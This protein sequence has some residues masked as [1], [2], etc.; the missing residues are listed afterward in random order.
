[1]VFSGRARLTA[2]DWQS[3]LDTPGGQAVVPRGLTPPPEVNRPNPTI[4]STATIM[5]VTQ[6]RTVRNLVHSAC[7]SWAKSPRLASADERR[8]LTVVIAPLPRQ[9]GQRG[10]PPHRG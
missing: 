7:S 4:T 9:P 1:M 5:P 8:G 3:A 6:P 2:A 10:I